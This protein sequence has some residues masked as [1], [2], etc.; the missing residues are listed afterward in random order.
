MAVMLDSSSMLGTTPMCPLAGVVDAL[1]SKPLS[2]AQRTMMTFAKKAHLSQ[3]VAYGG[4]KISAA[5]AHFARS[6]RLLTPYSFT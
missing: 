2:Y 3:L 6:S 4:G 5:N 1:H